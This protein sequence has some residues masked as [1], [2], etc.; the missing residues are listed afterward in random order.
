MAKLKMQIE[1]GVAG[2]PGGVGI[3]DIPGGSCGLPL[4]RHRR[5]TAR[6]TALMGPVLPS[7]A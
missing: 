6:F 5:I 7:S 4:G 2:S 1:M 3:H